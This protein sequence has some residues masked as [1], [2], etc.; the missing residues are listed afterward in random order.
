MSEHLTSITELPIDA[1]IVEDRLRGVSQAAVDVLKVSIAQSGLSHNITVRR[2]KDG[3]YLLDGAHRLTALRELGETMVPVKLVRCNDVEARLIEIDCNLAGQPLLP[4]DL[5]V[6]LAR[7][8]LAYE[9]LY[10]E[11]KAATGAD[12][13]AR[14]WDTAENISTVSFVRS[15]QAYLALSDRH[16]RNYVRAGMLLENA[17]VEALRLAPKRVD[18]MSLID[19]GKLGDAEE[20]GFV[21]KALSSGSAKKVSAARKAF[22]AERGEGPAPRNATDAEFSRLVDAWKR[23]SKAARRRFLEE[24]GA[25]VQAHLDEMGGSEE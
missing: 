22:R 15:V 17:E 2:K 14:R 23:A 25:D 10:P 11:A 6:F 3:D 19:I 21:V 5:A 4:V 18:V 13:V 9:E 8:K 7:R 24:H 1:I 16:I 20:R 12:L